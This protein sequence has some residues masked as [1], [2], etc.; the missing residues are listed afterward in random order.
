MALMY[1][2]IVFIQTFR[3]AMKKYY[4][5][6]FPNQTK[7]ILGASHYLQNQRAERKYIRKYYNNYLFIF[8]SGDYSFVSDKIC[9][10]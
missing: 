5:T 8:L 7:S 4:L 3:D 10:S 9:H 6:N 2:V 1:F